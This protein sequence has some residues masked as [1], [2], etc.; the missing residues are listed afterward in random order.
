MP[1]TTIQTQHQSFSFQQAFLLSLQPM[2]I[3]LEVLQLLFA[4]SSPVAWQN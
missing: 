1:R 3:V 2:A 4:Q